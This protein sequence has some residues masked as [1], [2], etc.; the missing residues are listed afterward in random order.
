MEIQA[1]LIK[2]NVDRPATIIQKPC[3]VLQLC[4]RSMEKLFHCFY[5]KERLA[6]GVKNY[7]DIALQSVVPKLF[8]N[9]INI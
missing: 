1:K 2:Y 5:S 4:I 7:R 9:R 8:Y 6:A 3:F